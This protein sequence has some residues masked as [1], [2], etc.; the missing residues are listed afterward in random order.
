MRHAFLESSTNA[1][2]ALL[3]AS[4]LGC[5]WELQRTLLVRLPIAITSATM[6]RAR[7]VLAQSV[8]DGLSKSYRAHAD[9]GEVPHTTVRVA[10]S[11]IGAVAIRSVQSV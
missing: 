2:A 11:R 3:Y 10:A 5:C 9:R 8:P 4:T 1:C 7:R 6:D